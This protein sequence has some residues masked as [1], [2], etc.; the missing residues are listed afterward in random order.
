MLQEGRE[1]KRSNFFTTPRDNIPYEI[2]KICSFLLSKGLG[3]YSQRNSTKKMNLMQECVFKCWLGR[4]QA[5]VVAFGGSGGIRSK[6]LMVSRGSGTTMSWVLYTSRRLTSF[7][8]S[9]GHEHWRYKFVI[10]SASQTPKAQKILLS[11]AVVAACVIGLSWA[12]AFWQVTSI[13]D[14]KQQV[15]IFTNSGLYNFSL[16]NYGPFLHI[17][18]RYPFRIELQLQN[19]S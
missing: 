8:T 2:Q 19:P 11:R 9:C 15:T 10:S 12:I 7:F 13:F 16:S 17:F 5:K 4:C 6:V 14:R 3:V 18:P 1:K